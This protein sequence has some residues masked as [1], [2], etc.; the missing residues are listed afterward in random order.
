MHLGPY[1]CFELHPTSPCAKELGY[2]RAPVVVYE[3]AGSEDHWS[4][5]NP[6]KIAQVIALEGTRGG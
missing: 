1:C 5:L 3:R 4:G 2:S 6:P